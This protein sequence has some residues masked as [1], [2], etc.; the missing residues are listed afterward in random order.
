M[1][2]KGT[3]FQ[4]KV[5]KYLKT[6]PKG[7]IRTY[8]DVAKEDGAECVLGGGK[9]DDPALGGGWFVQPTIY[10]G[11]SNSMRI[12][13]EEIFGPVLSVI[14]FKDDNHAVEI[15]NDVVYGLASGLWTQSIRRAIGISKL[16][17]AGTV[18]VNT[19]RAVSF[20][21][22]FGGYKR[23]GLGKESGQ[24]AIKD[25][26]QTKSVWISTATEVPNPFVIR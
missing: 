11:V 24:Q 1:T 4:L 5:W 8:F 9:P 25:Y 14:P 10:T 6:I 26:M 21:S 7:Q 15:A 16:I 20:V 19:Y 13:Q 3:K 18:W 22:P 2:L 17:Q 12:A 23:S